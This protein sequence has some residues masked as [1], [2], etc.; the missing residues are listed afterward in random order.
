MKIKSIRVYKVELP[1]KG[2]GRFWQHQTAPE[3]L[4]STIVGIETDGGITGYG[5]SCPIG[6]VFLEAFA[7]T[8]RAAI[9]RLA[10]M[11]LG[12]DPRQLG[13][14]NELMDALVLGHAH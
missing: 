5:E 4:D 12:Q 14:I 2:V 8:G 9:A 7:E 10:P 11:L 3:T 1:Y 6:S 13:R